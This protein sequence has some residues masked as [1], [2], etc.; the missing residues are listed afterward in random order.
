MIE[1]E[2]SLL[3]L[4]FGNPCYGAYHE[5][6]CPLTLFGSPCK[7]EIARRAREQKEALAYSGMFKTCLRHPW[8]ANRY[9]LLEGLLQDKSLVYDNKLV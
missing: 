1:Q 6:S 9:K 4:E 5:P 3:D 7:R 2:P 8:R